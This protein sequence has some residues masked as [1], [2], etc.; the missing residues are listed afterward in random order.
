MPKKRLRKKTSL[1]NRNRNTRQRKSASQL[2]LESLEIR[3]VLSASPGTVSLDNGTL[4]ICGDQNDNVII[5]AQ[6]LDD[7]FVSADFLAEPLVFAKSDITAVD[8]SAGSGDDRVVTTSLTDLD[9]LINGDGGDDLLFGSQGDDIVNGG[10]GTD[11]V[12]GLA[13]AD[14]LSSGAGATD[15]VFGGAGDDVITLGAGP[16]RAFGEDGDDIINGGPDADT[17]FGGAGN[18]S[19]SGSDGDDIIL[20]AAGD[21]MVL[22]GNGDDV[23]HGIDG[24]DTLMGNVGNDTII[25]GQGNDIAT[26]GEGDD[27]IFGQ[28]GDDRIDGNGGDD[29]ILAGD[30]I[31]TVSGGAGADMIAGGGGNDSLVGG[32]EDDVITGDGGDDTILGDAGDD[33]LLGGAG[34]DEILAGDGNDTLVG[35]VGADNLQGQAGSDR[36]FGDDG[37]DELNGGDDADELFGGAGTD[38]LI[39]AA[40]NDALTGGAGNDLMSGNEGDDLLFG[41]EGMDTIVGGLGA[42]VIVAGDD[43]DTVFGG[44]GRDILIGG[45]GV[46]ELN[47]EGGE[48]VVIGGFTDFDGTPAQLASLRSIWTNADT[49]EDRVAA[50]AAANLVNGSAGD[51]SDGAVSGDGQVDDLAGGADTDLFF[52][53][54]G[55]ANDQNVADGELIS[56]QVPVVDNAIPDQ[57]ATSDVPFSYTLPA[58]TFSDPEMGDL[59]FSAQVN[60]QR[61][62]QVSIENLAMDGG[63]SLTPFWLGLHN[64]SFDLFNVGSA[65][66]PGLELLAEDGD[67]SELVAEFDAAG[68]IQVSGIGNA[69]GFPGAPVIE[70]GEVAMTT[71][72]VINPAAYPF[73]SFASMVI[74]SNDAFLGNEDPEGY[75]L[76][77]DDGTFAGP[78]TI[79]LF[80]ADIWDAGTEVND[81]LGA[82]FST[83]GGDATDEN[84]TVQ[85]HA[86][87]SNFEGSDTP[88]GTIAIGA[89]PG[90]GAP[91]AR[92]TINQAPSLPDWLTFDPATGEFSGTPDSGDVGTFE[93]EVTAT[94]PEGLSTTDTF[95]VTV[96]EPNVAPVVDNVIPDQTAAADLPFDFTIPADTFSDPN[97]DDLTFSASVTGQEN[98]SI[99]FENVALDGGFSLTPLWVGLHDGSFDLFDDNSAAS[100]GVELL[101]E[102]GDASTLETEFAAAGR[103]QMSGIGNADGFPGAPVVEPGETATAVLNVTDS[104]L[105]RFLSFASMVIPSNDAFVG[106]EDPDAYRIFNNDGSFAGPVTIE[107]YGADIWDAGTEVND[108]MGAPFSTIGGDATDENGTIQTHVGLSNF[109]GTDTPAGTIAAGSAPGAGDLVAVITIDQS[110]ALPSWLSFDPATGQFTGTPSAD[111]VG[112]TT[113][114][115]TATDPDGLSVTTEFDLDVEPANRAPVVSTPIDNQ[116]ATEGEE[117]T[118]TIP[119]G[120]FTDPDGDNISFAAEV[121]QSGDL[122]FEIENLALD[123]GFSLTPFWFGLHNGSFDLFD[124][125]F[126][127][128]PG[129]ELLAEVGDASL[130]STEFAGAGRLDVSGV[131]A[132]EGFGGAPVIEPGEI[133]VG[134]LDSINP[135]AYPFLSF[136][137]MVIPSNDAF[138]GNE[139]PDAYRVFN[140]DGSFAGPLTIEIYGRDIWD[141]GTELNNVDGAAFSNNAGIGAEENGTVE[142]HP[143]LENFELTATPAGQIADGAAPGPDDLVARITI[144]E[145]T[146][147]P[148]WLV[149]DAATGTFTGTPA[150]GDVGTL[151][152]NVIATDDDAQDPRSVVDTFELVIAA[153]AP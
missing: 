10:D 39:G 141:A 17:I 112:T 148:D 54:D 62:L 99:S 120:T 87:L 102:D 18:D 86:G 72:D 143:G 150:A 77:N 140:A 128:S 132:P 139:D 58:D 122:M 44:D 47:G 152:I 92:I 68:R 52:V 23:L 138:V 67:A 6:S 79:E 5:V 34:Q 78:V 51:S 108:T 12:Y 46:D 110:S 57:L 124:D 33:T 7:I 75:R 94:D 74:P 64:G 121:E 144:S 26:G 116:A 70:P 65:A 90:A 43:D 133:A 55:D 35:G 149:F 82:P 125:G 107:I 113:V 134:T 37:D 14:R 21:D 45:N 118:F 127:A 30:G 136:A 111:D 66:S 106:N 32:S 114:E 73:L 130:L 100:A 153:M 147:L 80:G 71:I 4:N 142:L 119:A 28:L 59:T 63:F 93:V 25:S 81:T 117:F 103:I 89:A 2:G 98:I 60:E 49:Y 31:D 115:V 11:I 145:R 104:T 40:G 29:N 8:I 101:A 27:T 48:D 105:Q 50:L 88:A 36:L 146:I 84:G 53:A 19:L 123:G 24:N 109:E 69:D 42:D 16:N 61:D 131:G 22:G 126:A 1:N 76:Y 15:F 97:G 13:G 96:D 56:N 129:L 41:R 83:I 3:C 38:E 95:T 85:T 91:V 9:V 135:A 20:A 151:V 137:S